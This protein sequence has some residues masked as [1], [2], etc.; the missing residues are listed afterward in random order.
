M[1]AKPTR[2]VALSA[3]R[4]Q[5]QH[6]KSS[7]AHVDNNSR[8]YFNV[9]TRTPIKLTCSKDASL[10]RRTNPVTIR[11][12][13]HVGIKPTINAAMSAHCSQLQNQNSST[14]H[15][16]NND[17]FNSSAQM[18]TTMWLASSNNTPL[19]RHN[20]LATGPR[21]KPV[22]IEPPSEAAILAQGPQSWHQQSSAYNVENKNI[23]YSNV[24]TRT[25]TQTAGFTN[26]PLLGRTSPDTVYRH[27]CLGTI[28]LINSKTLASSSYSWHQSTPTLHAKNENTHSSWA[29]TQ[30]C[31][32]PDAEINL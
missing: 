17:I 29:Q 31:A 28:S 13:N 15:V 20:N 25:P 1:G 6:Q 21:Q 24:Q 8:F 22:G 27:E 19:R 3:R 26:K 32:K 2:N 12:Q 14:P 11:M 23:I 9:Q 4:S 30:T 5:S 7:T 18:Q 10:H 16:E